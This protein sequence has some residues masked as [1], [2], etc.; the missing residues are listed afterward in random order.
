[1]VSKKIANASLIAGLKLF[2]LNNDYYDGYIEKFNIDIKN[3]GN[4]E[5]D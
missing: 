1:M 2:G 3:L 4:I 5:M